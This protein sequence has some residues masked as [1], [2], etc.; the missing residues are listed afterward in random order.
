[1]SSRRGCACVGHRHVLA[2]IEGSENLVT[3]ITG[4]V[5][6]LKSTNQ[7]VEKVQVQESC[8]FGPLVVEMR[9]QENGVC[10]ESV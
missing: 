9:S 5:G 6:E 7:I 10:E 2:E 4:L 3:S 1:M 8:R